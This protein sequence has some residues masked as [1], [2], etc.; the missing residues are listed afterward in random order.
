MPLT[1]IHPGDGGTLIIVANKCSI[2]INASCRVNM[3]PPRRLTPAPFFFPDLSSTATA[4]PSFPVIA[5]MSH[6]AGSS[7]GEHARSRV[8]GCRSSLNHSIGLDPVGELSGFPLVPCPD[9][10]MNRVVEGQTRK[11]GENHG[12]LYFKCARNSV[13]SLLCLPNLS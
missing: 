8:Q 10:G 7:G 6:Y 1:G 2:V 13:S 9:C 12:R 4:R 11:E 3:H 5:H